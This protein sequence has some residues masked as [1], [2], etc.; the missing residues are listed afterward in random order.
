[1]EIDRRRLLFATASSAAFTLSGCGTPAAS[2][3]GADATVKMEEFQVP[4]LDA[5][6]QLYVRNK[7]PAAMTKSSAE[8]TI[9]FVHGATY[10]AETAFDL[11]LDG[12]S[13]MDYI[14]RRG[15]DVWLLDL[16]GYGRSTRPPEMNQAPEQNP[17][18]T[19]G[20]VAQRDLDAVIDFVRKQRGI[21][22]VS[23]LGWSWGTT[24][25]ATF[26]TRHPDKVARVVLYAPQFVRDNAI[27][28][29]PPAAPNTAYRVVNRAQ[30]KERWLNR[31]PAHARDTLIPAGWF[32]AWA[33]ATFAT[34]TAGGGQ[35]LR[36]TN[37]VMLDSSNSYWIG[38]PYYDPA[39]ITVPTLL[40]V[41]EW[42]ADT[43]TYMATALHERLT[44]APYKR[45]TILPEGTHTILMERNR[46]R[47]FEEVQR[48]LDT[49]R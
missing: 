34:D 32:E 18:L 27:S 1:M 16:R 42:D 2:G 46:M 9:V 41:G 11:P 49:G 47:L 38:K 17:P 12:V 40:I 39:Q 48:F 3:S 28:G 30:A 37:G 4:S 26:A 29:A 15:Y 22:R 44:R 21:D 14:A 20:V 5:G 6:I 31:V 35:T 13:W 33:D 43:P 24:L 25:M 23:L 19:T 8:K 45:L 36:A 10:P 7:R